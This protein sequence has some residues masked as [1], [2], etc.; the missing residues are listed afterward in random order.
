MRGL[1]ALNSLGTTD[2]IFFIALA[3]IV[4]LC[5]VVYFL[6]PVINRKQYREQRENL[7]K[8]EVAFKS[9]VQRTDGSPV[10]A[11]EELPGDSAAGEQT[12]QEETPVEIPVDP[13][14][15]IDEE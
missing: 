3:A 8:R 6:I 13:M 14:Q 11:E 5:V 1:L 12:Q 15:N 7:K 4:A 10:V 2:T 9:N